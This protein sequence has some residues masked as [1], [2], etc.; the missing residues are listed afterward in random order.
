VFVA[1]QRACQ[2]V[3]LNPRERLEWAVSRLLQFMGDSLIK[4]GDKVESALD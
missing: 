2:Q 1:K 3:R 4:M